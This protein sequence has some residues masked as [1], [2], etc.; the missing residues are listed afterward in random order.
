MK[1]KKSKRYKEQIEE[2]NSAI[3]LLESFIVEKKLEQEFEDFLN[4]L[5]H[6][7]SEMFQVDRKG[8]IKWLDHM[9]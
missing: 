2:L 8:G 1:I 5:L 3:S 4:K 6:E 7:W 9:K